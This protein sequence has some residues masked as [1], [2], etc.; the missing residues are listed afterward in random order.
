M[1]CAS[2]L[3]GLSRK[4]GDLQAAHRTLLELRNILAESGERKHKA[5]G[6]VE[7]IR[8]SGPYRWVGLYDVSLSMGLVSNIAWSGPSAPGY[9]TFPATEGLTSRA[10]ATKK[11]FNVGD[12]ASDQDY[13]TALSSTR[14]E[15]I[16][17]IFSK[18][19]ERVVGTI[20][21]ES[22]RCNAFD[23]TAQT[24]LEEFARILQPFW[25]E[26]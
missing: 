24:V 7:A 15:I 2:E 5:Q 12:V 9:P 18:D 19:G 8:T 20:D 14:S 21:V 4:F 17:P 22:E 25:S 11:T 13:L 10:I 3:H 23:S 26:R 1:V 6:I 16:I